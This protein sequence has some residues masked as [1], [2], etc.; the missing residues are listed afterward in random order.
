M[1]GGQNAS[2][3]TSSPAAGLPAMPNISLL[4]PGMLPAGL[5]PGVLT[6]LPTFY[7]SF[8]VCVISDLTTGL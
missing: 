8:F 1:V 7:C 6:F 4:Q 2:V 5:L 3:V